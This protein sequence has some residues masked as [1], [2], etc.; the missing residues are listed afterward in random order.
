MKA[1]YIVTHSDGFIELYEV[2]QL[3][4]MLVSISNVLI[5]KFVDEAL[6][7]FAGEKTEINI[8]EIVEINRFS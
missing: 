3:T 1:L 2:N 6:A 7:C 5:K 4:G 8:N